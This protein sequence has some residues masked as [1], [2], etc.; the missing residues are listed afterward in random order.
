[1]ITSRVDAGSVAGPYFL[2]KSSRLESW[3]LTR[4]GRSFRCIILGVIAVSHAHGDFIGNYD[5]SNFT[6]RNT[7]ADGFVETAAAPFSITLV[8]GNNGSGLRGTTDFVVAA[9]ESG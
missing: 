7:N 9:A 6:L 2:G 8:G 5:P 1:M 4:L 3:G